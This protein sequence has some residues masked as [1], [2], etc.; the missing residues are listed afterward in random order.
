M[1]FVRKKS[2]TAPPDPVPMRRNTFS[3]SFF[4]YN[5]GEGVFSVLPGERKESIGRVLRG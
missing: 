5:S 2:G 4:R 1:K 3:F